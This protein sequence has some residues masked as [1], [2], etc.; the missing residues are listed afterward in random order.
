MSHTAA[1]AN[2]LRRAKEAQSTQRGVAATKSEAR[3]SKLET[4]SNDQNSN[5]P[6]KLESKTRNLLKKIL[7]NRP[8]VVQR[9]VFVCP[10]PCPLCLS[11]EYISALTPM[12]YQEC[13]MA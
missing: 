1:Y 10:P 8:L 6:N 13:E 9:R 2:K 3:N 5:D 11:G 4:N 7:R 12:N